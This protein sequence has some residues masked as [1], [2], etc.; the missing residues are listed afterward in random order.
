M[1]DAFDAVRR[2]SPEVKAAI[3][4]GLVGVLGIVAPLYV[5]SGDPLNQEVLL[6]GVPALTLVLILIV[7]GIL[8]PLSYSI[9]TPGGI[10]APL[11]LLGAAM[12]ALLADVANAVLPTSDLSATAFAVVGMSTFF[13]AVVRAPIT[14]VLLIIEMTATTSLIV[15]MILAAGAAV[16]TSTLLKGEPIYDTLRHR[17]HAA[18]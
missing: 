7:R 15:P 3:I 10:F 13:A 1:I 12:G 16:I 9:G 11:L 17:L 5:G 6:G 14:A 8:G 2:L 4:G 18:R